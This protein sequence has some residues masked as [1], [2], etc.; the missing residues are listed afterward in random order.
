MQTSLQCAFA[1]RRLWAL[2]WQVNQSVHGNYKR[3]SSYGQT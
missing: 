2:L 1:L 3:V